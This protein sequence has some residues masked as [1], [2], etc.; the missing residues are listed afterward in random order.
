MRQFFSTLSLIQGIHA[1]EFAMFHT[2]IVLT[3][4]QDSNVAIFVLTMEKGF[5]LTMATQV[6]VVA[7]QL[8]LIVPKSLGCKLPGMIM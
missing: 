5:M 6:I 2:L 1:K 8:I 7:G 4:H 3:N